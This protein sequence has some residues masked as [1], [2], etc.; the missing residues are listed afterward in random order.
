M[1]SVNAV[2]VNFG[3]GKTYRTDR[4]A[5]LSVLCVRTDRGKQ[6][7]TW[8][9]KVGLEWRYMVVPTHWQGAQDTC[10][11]LSNSQK[12][13]WRVPGPKEILKAIDQGIQTDDNKAFGRDYLTYVWTGRVESEIQTNKVYAVD[14]RN[15]KELLEKVDSTLSVLCVRD[16]AH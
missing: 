10:T 16:L 12:L 6:S 3:D 4:Q 13:P 15:K 1:E 11:S 8:K 7:F 9:D 2:Y 5:R 14:L